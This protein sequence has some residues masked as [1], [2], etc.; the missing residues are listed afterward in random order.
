MTYLYLQKIGLKPIPCLIGAISWM[1]NGY[2]MVWFEFEHIPI[3]AF[4]TSSILYFIEVW[5]EKRTRLSFLC[6]SGLIALS[7]CISYAQLFIYQMIF[8]SFYFL[9]R[10]YLAIKEY[11]WTKFYILRIFSKAILVILISFIIS[12]NFFITHFISYK[13]GQRQSIPYSKLFKM[14]GQVL[15]KYLMTTLFPDIFGNPT[16]QVCFTPYT[17][18][19]QFYNN[20]N[21]LC[22]YAGIVPLFLALGCIPFIGKR[23]QINFFVISAFLSLLM[24]MG[25]IFYYPLSKIP[26]LSLSTPT[27]ILYFWGFSISI[28][29]GLCAD[30]LQTEGL[31]RR[32]K[33]VLFIWLLLILVSFAI[34][35]FAMTK[36]GKSFLIGNWNTVVPNAENMLYNSDISFDIILKP[37]LVII[38]AFLTCISIIYAP[39]VK[40]KNILLS[41]LIILL[42]YDLISFGKDYNTVSPRDLEYP[43][44]SAISFL[45]KDTTKF[46][47]LF[48]GNFLNNG[49]IPFD[50]EDI[51]GYSSFYPKR[52]G[53]FSNIMQYGDKVPNLWWLDRGVFLDKVSAIDSPLL[54]LINTKYILIPP[55][56]KLE[57]KKL[58]LVYDGEIKIYENLFCLNRIFFVKNYYLASNS[59]DAYNTIKRFSREDFSN[60]VILEKAPQ[61]IT[62]DISCE[63]SS[64]IEIVSYLSDKIELEV[65]S[66]CNGFI[67]ISDSYDSNWETK[68]DGIKAETL[69]ANYIMRAIPVTEG[70]HK[71]ILTFKPQLVIWGLMI[72][73][74]GWII[75]CLF[76]I[77]ELLTYERRH[78]DNNSNI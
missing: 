50:I 44:T 56:S 11:H 19:T 23:K 28:L 60:K 31:D 27:R 42:S 41:L 13:Q 35:I 76:I 75:L 25:T 59:D 7:I 48:F 64:N 71:I 14:T 36:E 37:L 66:K 16:L 38:A 45:K 49:F 21:E 2:V 10:I 22:I 32:K 54:D 15:P 73:I 67:V 53:E 46:R 52:Y 74:V 34:A 47:I 8:I 43:K 3:F 18:K 30:F 63:A 72:T 6:L 51:G 61:I 78:I 29:S 69:R 17:K 4:T 9:Y 77:K 20:Y 33:I 62:N 5:I 70:K 39:S 40:Y 24:A 55:Y 26:A 58:K 65:Y 1:F 68:V 12:S 57:S